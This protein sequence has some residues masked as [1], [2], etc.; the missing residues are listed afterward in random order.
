LDVTAAAATFEAA[1]TEL[2]QIPDGDQRQELQRIWL[3][4][5]ADFDLRHGR[6]QLAFDKL[7]SLRDKIDRQLPGLIVETARRQSKALIAMEKYHHNTGP[8]S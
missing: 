4:K 8:N 7:E 1:A 6:S 2:T 5:S 3:S